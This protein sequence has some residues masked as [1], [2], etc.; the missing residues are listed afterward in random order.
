MAEQPDKKNCYPVLPGETCRCGWAYG[1]MDP[2]AVLP[3]ESNRCTN[4]Y[5]V[6]NLDAVECGKCGFLATHPVARRILAAEKNKLRALRGLVPLT[7]S[8]IPTFHEQPAKIVMHP[9]ASDEQAR[10]LHDRRA[11]SPGGA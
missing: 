10:A 3:A 2:H 1:S 6:F 8:E 5:A 9:S 7:G 4:C 11:N